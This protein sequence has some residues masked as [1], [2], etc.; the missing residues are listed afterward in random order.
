MKKIITAITTLSLL[1]GLGL[2]GASCTEAEAK[3]GTI[4]VRVTDAPPGYEVTSIEVT[5]LSVEVHK[6]G[7]NGGGEWITLDIV[8][9]TF[10]LLEL[11]GLE[12]ILAT[13]VV[14]AGKY[15]QLRMTVFT[16]EV[17]YSYLED[18][19]TV[20]TTVEAT[21]PSGELKFV[22]PFDLEAG[23][24]ITLLLDFDAD[25]SVVITGNDKVI[26]NP[27]VTLATPQSQP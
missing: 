18:G 15:T 23:E 19:E 1:A 12:L 26:F 11:E 16:V 25:K 13:E 8:E 14:E 10:N 6:A 21:I 9:E 3:T 20:E 27:V 5:V 17:T 22:R 4:E 7:D 2:A 24:T